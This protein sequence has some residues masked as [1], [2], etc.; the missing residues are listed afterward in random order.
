MT[1]DSVIIPACTRLWALPEAVDS[2]RCAAA[3]V[4]IVVVDDGSTNGIGAFLQTQ[5]DIVAIRADNWRSRRRPL[6]LSSSHYSAFLFRC[7]LIERSPHRQRFRITR[8][9]AVRCG[10]LR[11]PIR[12]KRQRS[13]IGSP[14]SMWESTKSV[15]GSHSPASF[16][17]WA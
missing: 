2:C 4:E 3:K 15:R 10:R 6:P 1:D 8:R 14:I 11:K 9:P 16:R 12:K 13:S 7:D 5:R 17:A